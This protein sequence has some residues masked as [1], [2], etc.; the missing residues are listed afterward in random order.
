VST[1]Q[2]LKVDASGALKALVAAR[3][4]LAYADRGL[5]QGATLIR[6]DWVRLAPK[7]EGDLHRNIQQGRIAVLVHEI[8]SRAKHGVFVEKGTGIYGPENRPL[9]LGMLPDS[10]VAA[11]ARWIQRKGITARRVSQEALPWVI[12][13]K[14][15]Q[16]GTPAQPSAEL[17]FN[18]NRAR[19]PELVNAAIARGIADLGLAGA[20]A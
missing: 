5:R 16:R 17:A 4:L 20:G 11:I 19:V 2:V 6:R 10:G 18:V 3:Q 14:I 7:A 8:V 15:A 12:A 9:G 1:D 13:R